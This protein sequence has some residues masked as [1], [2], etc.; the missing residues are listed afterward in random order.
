MPHPTATSTHLLDGLKDQGNQ[1][2]WAQYVDRYRPMIVGYCARLG[3]A[4]HDAEDIAQEALVAFARRYR[5]G[6]YDRTR[7]RLRAWLFG[8]VHTEIARWRR[9]R[10]RRQEQPGASPT[11]TLSAV[12]D[13]DRLAALWEEEWRAA[14]VGQCT[15]LARAE[16]GEKTFAAFELFACQGWPAK[17]VAEHLGTSESAVFVA[18]HRVL[19]RIR[20]LHPR[21]DETW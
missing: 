21:L 7:G 8:M 6:D 4:A 3:V 17:R 18:K 20:E 2:V 19:R 13:Q 11:G 10:G 15:A 1:T 5:A 9:A 12:P 16:V 14:V